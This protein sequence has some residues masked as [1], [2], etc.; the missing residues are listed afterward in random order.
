MFAI[1]H[2]LNI[3]G[4]TQRIRLCAEHEGLPPLLVVQAGPGLPLLHEVRKFQR[5][6]NLERDFLVAYWE[7]RGCGSAP[8]RDANAVSLRQQVD[9]LRAVLRWLH[10]ETRQPILL[11]GISLGGAIALQAAGEDSSLLTALVVISPDSQTAI[12]DAAVQRFLEQHV[13]ARGRQFER[14]LTKLGPPPYLDFAGFQGRARLLADLGSIE[15]GRKSSQLLREMLVNLVLTYG[16]VGTI[17]TFR[18]LM[19]IQGRVLPEVE[20][21]DLLANPPGV[22]VP[23]H[24]VFGEQDALNP[25]DLVQQL[26]VKVS[27][28]G[29]TVIVLCE[30]AHMVHF[31]HPEAVRSIAVRALRGK[32]LGVTRPF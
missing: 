18:N 10:T 21:L 6:L 7:Q 31:D 5:L 22:T 29:S 23:I 27:A 13:Q 9:D 4:S 8:A 2:T 30:A 1:D 11:F 32:K 3:N 15:H 19:T 20:S 17:K 25:A 26:P 12:S 14:A 28:P 24:Y 16:V